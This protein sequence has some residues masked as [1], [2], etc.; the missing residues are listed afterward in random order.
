MRLYGITAAEVEQVLAHPDS[1]GI[2]GDYL[3]ALRVI[4][5]RFGNVP[6][7]AVYVIED[8][9]VVVSVYPLIRS[10]RK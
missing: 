3:I 10:H 5:G 1:H 8:D 6:L 9:T 7:K 2:D 4:S